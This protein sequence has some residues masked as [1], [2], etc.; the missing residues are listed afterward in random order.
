MHTYVYTYTY[1]YIYICVCICID[2]G[3]EQ[4]QVTTEARQLKLVSALPKPPAT[5]A[6]L[7][8]EFVRGGRGGSQFALG[9]SH[10]LVRA[11]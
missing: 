2:S 8:S 10:T 1:I 11:N 7:T 9:S 3:S 4:K 5:E 6:A